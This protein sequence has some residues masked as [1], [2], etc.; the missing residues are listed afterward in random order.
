MLKVN[1]NR[2]VQDIHLWADLIWVV[3]EIGDALSSADLIWIVEIRDALSSADLIWIVKEIRD[4]LSSSDLIWIVKEI[5]NALS[6]V[7]MQSLYHLFPN[8]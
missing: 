6:S 5:G 7:Y 4:A 2:R 1:L 3:K 8:K